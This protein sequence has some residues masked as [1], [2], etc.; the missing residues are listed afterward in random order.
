M[1]TYRVI[2][3]TNLDITV[4]CGSFFYMHGQRAEA[5]MFYAAMESRFGF[6]PGTDVS[7]EELGMFRNIDHFRLWIEN[8][9]I[10]KKFSKSAEERPS[11]PSRTPYPSE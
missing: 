4:H 8:G 10:Y 9:I 3:T 6:V 1:A 7:E 11:S 2:T 5:E